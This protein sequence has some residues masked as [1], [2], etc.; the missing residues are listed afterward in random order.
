MSGR[1]IGTNDALPAIAFMKD[2]EDKINELKISKLT[3]TTYKRD[4][5]AKLKKNYED[6][7]ERIN[8]YEQ[9]QAQWQELKNRNDDNLYK[10]RLND[11]EKRMADMHFQGQLKEEQLLETRRKRWKGAESDEESQMAGIATL[12]MF[13]KLNVE[14]SI[15]LKI[16]E[17]TEKIED[18]AEK[19]KK[20]LLTL[21]GLIGGD[22]VG[23]RYDITIKTQSLP[24]AITDEQ[25]KETI[26]RMRVLQRQYTASGALQGEVT[27]MDEQFMIN[28]LGDA[29][30]GNNIHFTIKSKFLA[31]KDEQNAN[32]DSVATAMEKEIDRVI[33]LRGGPQGQGGGGMSISSIQ[34][35][36]TQV[37]A[38]AATTGQNNYNSYRG[39]GSGQI[40]QC[41]NMADTGYCRF[42]DNCRYDHHGQGRSS[43]SSSSTGE[44]RRGRDNR[45]RTSRG[46]TS[47]SHSRERDHGG[48]RRTTKDGGGYG[49]DNGS[50]STSSSGR[51][52]SRSR[53]GEDR[54]EGS[55]GRNDGR[56]E[57]R[58][59]S[60]AGR[61]N[62]KGGRT[63]HKEQNTNYYSSDDGE[64][65][66]TGK[67]STP[68]KTG[69]KH[70]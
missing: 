6:Q 36:S 31:A 19:L 47:R 37:F 20:M 14:P 67:G 30:M 38:N 40:L 28:R 54:R 25:C 33:A 39:S 68:S 29:T 11:K 10:N 13:I 12:H 43:S 51:D 5:I 17:D 44:G 48:S 61:D 2:I 49:K 65:T 66:P 45:E 41:Y 35:A 55:R 22:Q 46:S 50:R 34:A 62:R 63:N 23:V 7:H 59:R 18:P 52:R 4:D 16:R 69:G 26:N 42:G 32:F 57:Y 3:K 58:S 64:S 15:E 24:P 21:K 53:E 60:P 9:I 27:A 8:D 56:S 1:K 70:F